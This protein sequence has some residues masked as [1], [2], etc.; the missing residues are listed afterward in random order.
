MG[1]IVHVY[2]TRLKRIVI[3]VKNAN[4]NIIYVEERENQFGLPFNIIKA[5]CMEQ[6]FN[7]WLCEIQ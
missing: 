6:W 2:K 7:F 5:Q 1:Q 4:N 3:M